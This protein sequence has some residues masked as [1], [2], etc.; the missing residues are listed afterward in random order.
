MTAQ[1]R[2]NALE[3]VSYPAKISTFICGEDQRLVR[4]ILEL[5]GA[6]LGHN[7]LLRHLQA[8]IGIL[9]LNCGSSAELVY[10]SSSSWEG[11]RR[12]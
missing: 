7:L 3:V 6:N 8:R 12:T 10:A 2:S 11:K 1:N 5:N 9:R 4:W